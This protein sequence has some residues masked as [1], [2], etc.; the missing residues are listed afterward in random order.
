MIRVS[1]DIHIYQSIICEYLDDIKQDVR[2]VFRD[3]RDNIKKSTSKI[4]LPNIGNV[5][6]KL[7][8]L[9]DS[10]KAGYVDKRKQEDAR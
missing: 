9:K 10:V 2:N 1:I 8:D 7:A 6:S 3:N 4:K 5:V